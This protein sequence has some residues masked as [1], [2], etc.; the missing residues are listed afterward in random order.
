[1][2]ANGWAAAARAITEAYHL[3]PP[4][5]RQQVYVWAGRGTINGN[6]DPFPGARPP[7]DLAAVVA[8]YGAG[9]T[10]PG[11]AEWETPQQRN[12]RYAH[13]GPADA[14]R[15]RNASRLAKLRP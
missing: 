2:P 14:A 3:D 6:G 10:A 12:E 1:M 15:R 7:L 9:V 5:T 8:W 4:I 11:G 13:P